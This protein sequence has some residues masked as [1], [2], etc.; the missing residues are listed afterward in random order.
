MPSYIN[1]MS[2]LEGMP[3][4]MDTNFF[5]THHPLLVIVF[6]AW[7]MMT[8]DWTMQNAIRPATLDQL[9]AILS[10]HFHWFQAL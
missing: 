4:M 2:T 1:A 9:S 6:L 5:V 7:D 3:M 8:G 10:C